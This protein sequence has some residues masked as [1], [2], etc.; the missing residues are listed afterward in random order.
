MIVYRGHAAVYPN[1][2]EGRVYNDTWVYDYKADTWTEMKPKR[3]PTGNDLRFMA[4][5]PVNDVAINVT[6]GGPVN[7]RH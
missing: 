7:P 6:P 2:W 5:D 3:F 1:R 4:F